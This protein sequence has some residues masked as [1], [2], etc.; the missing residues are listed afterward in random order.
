MIRA[1]V[2]E[3]SPAALQEAPRPTITFLYSVWLRAAQEGVGELQCT[4]RPQGTTAGGIALR[5]RL[6]LHVGRPQ[7]RPLRSQIG[8]ALRQLND[9]QVLS[10]VVIVPSRTS[11][12]ADVAP[13]IE[14]WLRHPAGDA[15]QYIQVAYEGQMVGES[16]RVPRRNKRF[17]FE[18]IGTKKWH[19][20]F[21]DQPSLQSLFFQVI[22]TQS[23]E[24]IAGASVQRPCADVDTGQETFH[25][26]FWRRMDGKQESRDQLTRLV[27]EIFVEF[28]AIQAWRALW[29]WIPR[30]TLAEENYYTP[31][32]EAKGVGNP[33]AEHQLGKGY[34]QEQWCSQQLRGFGE[35][36]WL[37]AAL[38]QRID[39]GALH[40]LAKTTDLGTGVV[41]DLE[42]HA[43]LTDL[44][45]ALEAIIPP[46]P[47]LP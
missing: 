13:K 24:A 28:T 37:G 5:P 33:T 17:K 30:F 14:D 8:D 15:P 19:K 10:A 23:D 43:S 44:E 18:E 20:L 34:M 11:T 25:L 21:A 41:L 1:V 42:A 46:P 22:E 2:D 4:F 45:T 35:R 40:G 32:E 26:G 36:L 3:M 29:N 16:F 6:Q 9:P 7:W 38:C 31:Y 27:D 39:R 47:S 12:L